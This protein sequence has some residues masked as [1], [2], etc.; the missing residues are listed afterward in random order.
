MLLRR[1]AGRPTV[2]KGC[3]WRPSSTRIP[4]K[5]DQELS[6][7]DTL[8]QIQFEQTDRYYSFLCNWLD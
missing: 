4:V 6:F 5:F 1:I 3:R 2:S 8:S 7:N